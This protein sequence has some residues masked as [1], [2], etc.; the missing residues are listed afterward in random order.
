RREWSAAD[1]APVLEK[2]MQRLALDRR[3][4]QEISAALKY[5]TTN[6]ELPGPTGESNTL[7]LRGKGVALALGGGGAVKQMLLCLA[8][9][10]VVIAVETDAAK[11]LAA[12]LHDAGAPKGALSLAGPHASH[13]L[14][15]DR[16]IRL[17]AFDGGADARAAVE[18]VLAER[19]GPILA[20]VSSLD[21][22]WRYA[23]ERA[24]TINTTAAGGDV[25]LLSL[26]E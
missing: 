25:R 12:A 1:R 7:R 11:S 6:T 15:K 8:A 4:A 24:L 2:A 3:D 13:A 18:A 9:G 23:A 26:T 22:P 5:F 14:L 10:N 20:V 17:L 19:K 16:R 21:A